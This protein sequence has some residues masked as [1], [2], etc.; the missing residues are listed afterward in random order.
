MP[1][2]DD[3]LKTVTRSEERLQ[4]A[5][6]QFETGRVRIRRTIV[7]EEV[8]HSIPVSHEELH[9]ERIPIDESEIA[10]AEPVEL[11]E[12]EHEITLHGER[13]VVSKTTVPVERYRIGSRIVTEQ[14]EVNE[15]LRK[16][17]IDL[18]GDGIPDYLQTTGAG[19]SAD[20]SAE[21][22]DAAPTGNGTAPH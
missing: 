6:E 22:N 21:H 16:E 9:I 17:Q 4:I 1:V 10:T 15:T 14:H 5:K 18:D 7:T 11:G 12:H 19:Q 2:T 20:R 13:P 3:G 8:T